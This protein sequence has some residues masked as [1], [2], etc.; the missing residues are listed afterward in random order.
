MSVPGRFI[1][2]ILLACL[3]ALV[4]GC[5]YHPL[6]S[7]VM[8]SGTAVKSVYIPVFV[9]R[10]FRP[11]LEAIL[12]NS[13]TD[14]FALRRGEWRIAGGGAEYILSG[15]ILSY[16]RTPVAYTRQDTVAE[17]RSTITTEIT[18]KR[19]GA[20]NALFKR[21]FSLFQHFPAST[22]ISI[23]QSGEDAAIQQICT[24]MAENIYV[25]LSDDF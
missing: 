24:R 13:I 16:E 12:A 21:R 5:G 3:L 6:N 4:G 23:L 25:S 9:N 15:V 14:Q 1:I 7:T 17:Y 8:G 18:L 22:D 19:N 10:S 11:N 2:P 20:E